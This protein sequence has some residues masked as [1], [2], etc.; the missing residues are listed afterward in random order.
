MLQNTATFFAAILASFLTITVAVY[1]K[2]KYFS[3]ESKES[4]QRKK[5]KEK[6]ANIHKR[7]PQLIN[8]SDGN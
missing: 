3:K 1:T 5:E 4:V 8:A 2:G 7:N 6:N